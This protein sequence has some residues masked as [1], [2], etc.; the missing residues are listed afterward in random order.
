MKHRKTDKKPDIAKDIDRGERTTL[1]EPLLLSTDSPHRPSLTDLALDL[2]TNS[3]RLRSTL[4]EGVRHALA[5][6]VRAMNCY[7]SNLIEGHDTHPVEIERALKNDYSKDRAKRNLQLEA[8][9]HISVQAWIDEGGLVGR[10]STAEAI[11]EIHERFCSQLPEDL[12]WVENPDGKKE[13][14]IPGEF[15]KHDVAVGRH[16]PIS[17][18]AV[19]RFLA[20]FEQ[21]YSQLGKAETILGAAAAHHR[22][23][24]IHPF[25]DGNGRVAR[26]VSYAQLLDTLD[27]GGIWSIARGLARNNAVYKQHL[28]AC[29]QARSNDLDGRGHLSEEALT[30]FTRFFLA[31]CLDQVSFMEGLVQPNRLRERILL[32]AEE[33]ARLGGLTA[34]A[35]V[36]LESI[37]YRGELQRGDIAH[38]IGLSDRQGRRVVSSLVEQ[39]VLT[40]ETDRAP[41]RL[42][43]PARLASRWMPGLFPDA[44]PA[45]PKTAK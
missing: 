8:K 27:T 3:A 26:L 1:M 39:G 41:L 18:G 23:L 28:M 43:F 7:Y 5:D 37:L 20:R 33:E 30:E 10:P 44:P 15:R 24:W 31:T 14:V 38:L 2:A 25:L 13:K 29:D 32:W 17:S 9:A 22:L 34:K 12:L 42:S 35:G 11:L 21:V 36:I 45:P 16:L 19:S 40:S 4:P 6:L